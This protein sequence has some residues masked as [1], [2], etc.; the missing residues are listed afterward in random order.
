MF[1][2][3]N[4]AKKG[5]TDK[6]RFKKRFK[7]LDSRSLSGVRHI[8]YLYSLTRYPITFYCFL[9]L[10]SFFS[11][12]LSTFWIPPFVLLLIEWVSGL[13]EC[14]LTVNNC[15]CSTHFLL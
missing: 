9:Y 3:G 2:S 10:I 4:L 6:Y 8:L 11:A 7:K 15:F 5:E 12:A 13:G 14:C 1:A